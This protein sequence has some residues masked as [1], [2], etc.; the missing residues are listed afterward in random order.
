MLANAIDQMKIALDGW[1][2]IAVKTDDFEVLFE[3]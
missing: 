3:R 2:N 1:K